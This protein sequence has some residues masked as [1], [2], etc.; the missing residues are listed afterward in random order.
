MP[1]KR[2]SA[3]S[4]PFIEARRLDMDPTLP[5]VAVLRNL[6]GRVQARADRE[7][8]RERAQREFEA[9]KAQ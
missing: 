1:L 4:E 2:L 5:A 3:S 8:L 9:W 6:I 7:G